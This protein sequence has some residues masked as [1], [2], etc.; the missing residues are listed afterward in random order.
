[1]TLEIPRE[2]F[3]GS[4][5]GGQYQLQRLRCQDDYLDIY[6]VTDPDGFSFE[7][8]AFS[9]SGLTAKLLHTR[10]RRIKRLVQ[11]QNFVCEIEQAGKRFLIIDVKRSD[12][13]WK[14]LGRKIESDVPDWMSQATLV[15]GFPDLS[16]FPSS[17]RTSFWSDSITEVV[18][19]FSSTHFNHK[20]Y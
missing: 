2:N 19:K 20:T 6:S 12:A 13:E 3:I 5:L 8:Q 9:L 18:G 14:N 16:T 11:S 4:I 1:M 15:E 7:A 10:K 17:R